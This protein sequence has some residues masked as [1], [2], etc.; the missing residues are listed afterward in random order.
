MTTT[1]L[2]PTWTERLD[3]RNWT[4]AWKLI[5]IGLVPA[6]LALTLGVLRIADQADDASLLGESNRLLEIRGQVALAADALRQ[7]RNEAAVFVAGGRS[8]ER[9]VLD[10]G[11]GQTDAGVQEAL[12]AVRATEEFDNTTRA[13][14]TQTEDALGQLDALRN[15]VGTSPNTGADAVVAR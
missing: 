5:A 11:I 12:A 9:G 14:L 8:E 2:R 6:L 3:P 10:I 13:A 4:L 1:E 15:D 7:E